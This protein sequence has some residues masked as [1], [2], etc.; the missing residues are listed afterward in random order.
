MQGEA[1]LDEV[2]T[3]DIAHKLTWP[4]GVFYQLREENNHYLNT[5]VVW[6]LRDQPLTYC[7]VPAVFWGLATVGIAWSLGRAHRRVGVQAGWLAGA[8][9]A[10]SY[11]MVHY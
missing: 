4:G 5:L 8:L 9:T 6:L 7:R 2:W 10:T 3:W 11:L 1:W